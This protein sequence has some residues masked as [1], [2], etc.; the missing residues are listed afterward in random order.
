MFLPL[1]GSLLLPLLQTA[2]V[3]HISGNRGMGFALIN[4][5][6]EAH[7][8]MHLKN[9]YNTSLSA[10]QLESSSPHVAHVTT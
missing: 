6:N 8:K 4:T 5:L 3:V 7:R 10:V 2:Y 1:S 9:P